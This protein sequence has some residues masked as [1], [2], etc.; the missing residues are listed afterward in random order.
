M[1]NAFGQHVQHRAHARGIFFFQLPRRLAVHIGVTGADVHPHVFKGQVKGLH[2]HVFAHF[3]DQ[4][5]GLGQHCVVVVGK[6]AVTWH[7]AFAVF[8]HHRQHTLRQ[9]AQIVGQFRIH[10]AHHGGAREITVVAERHFAH[11]E[12]PHRVQAIGFHQLNG[13]NDVAQRL[14]NLLPFVGPPPVGEHALGRFDPGG[15]QKGGPI[16]GVKAQDVLAHHVQVG[17]PVG[18]KFPMIFIGIANGGDVVCERVQPHVHDVIVVARHRNAPLER[19]ARN[20]Q[21]VQPAFDKA[22]DLVA[23]G[24]GQNEVRVFVIEL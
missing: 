15:H 13:I 17:G 10:P 23:P 22:G 14:G 5:M 20:R 11:Q 1:A 6:I 8:A 7:R 4:A 2:V 3:V 16:D 18:L 12:E 24:F 21:I 19:G 9:I